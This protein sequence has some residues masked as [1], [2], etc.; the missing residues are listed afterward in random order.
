MTLMNLTGCAVRVISAGDREVF[1]KA[2][3]P[4]TP[5]Q[6][7]VFMTETRYQRYRQAVA[8]EILKAKSK[9]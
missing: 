1:V 2:G 3:Q 6:D 4:F 8:D 9:P 7:G 5:E